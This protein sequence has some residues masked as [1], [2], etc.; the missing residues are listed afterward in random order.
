MVIGTEAMAI[1]AIVVGG[2]LLIVLALTEWD[3]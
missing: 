2:V 3:R 1:V